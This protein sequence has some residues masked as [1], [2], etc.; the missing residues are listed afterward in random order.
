MVTITEQ[1]KV[2]RREIG[3]RKTFYPKYVAEG[4]MTQ[5]EANYQIEAMEY[6]LN[7]LQ[8]VLEFRRG[9]IAK[10]EKLFM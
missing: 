4:K 7:T 9:Y 6:V 8:A 5:Q 10:N 2:V 3:K 1:I